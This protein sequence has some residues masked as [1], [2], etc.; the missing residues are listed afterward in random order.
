MQYQIR[1]QVIEPIRPTF[2]PLINRYGGRSA[3]RYEEGSVDIQAT[4]NFHYRPLWD[5]QHELYDPNY[6]V[7]RLSDPYSFTDPRQL[8]Y[9]PYVTSRAQLHDAFLKT[10]DYINKRDL[11]ARL[12]QD[13]HAALAEVILPLRHYECAA[14][15]VSVNGGRFAYGTTIEQC[16]SYAAFDRIGLA[17]NL[18]R[19]GIALGGNSDELLISAKTAWMEDADLQGLRRLAEELIVEKDWAIA[20]YVLDLTDQLIFPLL[21]GNLDEA[22][23]L[24]GAGSYSLLAQHFGTWYVDQRKWVD[25]L[26]AAW[27]ADPEHGS[28][29]AA[30]LAGAAQRWLP[31]VRDAV[32]AFASAVDRRVDVGA[33]AAVADLTK[34]AE[35]KLT[36]SGI[37]VTA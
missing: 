1:Q 28:G 11:L 10:L 23:L 15:L 9:A 22:A 8:Y 18:S 20:T 6:S 5:P 30:V 13:W 19:I 37:E 4:E 25:A 36:T 26:L 31:K 21:T 14:E 27:L 35:E 17:Q 2:T 33:R 24:A 32:G 12:P 29:N 16:L 34:A 7:L 3:T